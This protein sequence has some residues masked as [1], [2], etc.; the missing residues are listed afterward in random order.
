MD[1]V[2]VPEGH[3]FVMGDNRA[4]SWDS[5]AKGTGPISREAIMG[6]AVCVI[7]PHDQFRWICS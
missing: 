5:R 2:T 1:A 6:H 4:H 3:V 7:W